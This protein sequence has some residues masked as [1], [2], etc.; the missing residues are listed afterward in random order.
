MLHFVLGC[1]GTGKTTLLMEKLRRS[2]EQAIPCILLVPEQYSFEAERQVVRTLGPKAALGVEVLSFTRLC[3]SV[4]RSQGGLAGVQV[5]QTGRYLLMSLAVAEIQDK[6]KVYRKSCANTAFLETLVSVCSEFKTA[7]VSPQKLED[8]HRSC[9]SGQLKEKLEDL[10]S[11]YGTYQ[12]LLEKGYSDPD[13]NIMRACNLLK[14][15][16]IFTGK[17]L[18]IDGFVTFMAAEFEL[19]GHLIAQT[20]ETHIAIT[21]D[22]L[23]DES[24]GM[25]VFSIGKRTIRRLMTSA[26]RAGIAV[27]SPTILSEPHRYQNGELA[28][29]SG[30]F[31]QDTSSPHGHPTKAVRYHSAENPYQEIGFVADQIVRLVR[32]EGYRYRDIAVISRE[33]SGYLRAL[34]LTFLQSGIPYFVDD[35]KD[36]ET[37]PLAAA[38]L[39]ATDAVRGN[40]HPDHVLAWAKNPL[41]GIAPEAVAELENYC[42]C[43]DI[44][45]ALWTE[46]FR[47]NPSGFGPMTEADRFT[48]QRIDATRESVIRPLA[49]LKASLRDCDGRGFASAL[50]HFLLNSQVTQ[51]LMEFADTLPTGEKETFLA[52]SAGF[53]DM[54][55]ETLDV[56]GGVLG[57]IQLTTAR[58]C[59]LLRL[60]IASGELGVM[61]QTLDQVLVGKADRIRPGNVRAVFVIGAVEGEFPPA[62]L[63]TGIFT[64]EERRTMTQLGAEIGAPSLD[65]AVLEK[66]YCY[67]SL[68]LATEKLF[69]SWHGAKMSG[70]QCQPSVIV[71][72]IQQLFPQLEFVKADGFTEFFVPETA[73]SHLVGHYREDSPQTAA[74]LDYFGRK[75]GVFLDKISLA[76][77]KPTHHIN[78]R[79]TAQRLFGQH[80]TLSPSRIERYHR[81]AFAYFAQD[82]LKVKPRTKV[83]F[84]PLESGSFVHHVLQV[85]VQRYGKGLFELSTNE[86]RQE[87]EEVIDGYLAER[88]QQKDAIPKRFPYLFKRLSESL[89]RLLRHLGEE[90][91][92][93]E[94]QPVAFE[95]PINRKEGVPP[96]RLQ[97]ADGT[98]VVVEG[99]VDRVDIMEKNGNKY[100]RVVDY[101]SGGKE[102]RLDDVMYGIN[103]Q[104]LL[105]LFTIAENGT[106]ELEDCIPGGVLYLPVHSSYINTERGENDDAIREQVG[107]QWKMSGLLLDDMEN[108]TG[109]EKELAGIY[110][111]AKLGKGGMQKTS[112]LA[113]KAEMGKLS[114]KIK[115]LISEMAGSLA[116]G[117]VAACPVSSSGHNPCNYCDYASLCG[118][119]PG[120][121]AIT[122]AKMDRQ[123]VLV[124][125]M[126][127]GE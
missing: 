111:P 11:I 67:T 27:A 15:C 54:L 57:T 17:R 39:A 75:Q 24:Q 8:V 125:L 90:F 56:F 6:L 92:Q 45:G 112:A 96:L 62:A 33:T 115:D 48:L 30:H 76:A 41:S 81:C 117:G 79:A 116:R 114:R 121:A 23:E 87:V 18:F 78:D 97:T 20:E 119:E 77:S 86:L 70:A 100:V 40:Y 46:Q 43:W 85:M 36:V 106:G 69:L 83:D 28:Y 123:A 59:E 16:D 99:I 44:R 4:F 55:M 95:L 9:E 71:T 72:Q 80:M 74:L 14:N 37:M 1:G 10:T 98:D 113:G 22:S 88:I 29:L 19:L 7:G 73:K 32:K 65:M 82:G 60:S 52:E 124:Q 122:I 31:L 64:D 102:F 5:T 101:K 26:R 89:V 49:T 47:N 84:S 108:L 13:D 127:E 94:Y 38:L 118:F 107:K 25:G 34:E 58:F 50:Y 53:W 93:S 68:T 126:E 105:Y 12:A 103:L 110:I 109:M 35:R 51:N 91:A 3:D 21:A 42:Y 66:Y 61:P 120:D 104:M 2:A 63:S